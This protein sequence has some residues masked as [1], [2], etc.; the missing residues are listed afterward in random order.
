MKDR[1]DDPSHNERTHLWIQE[2]KEDEEEEA[3]RLQ[4]PA[5]VPSFGPPL[6]QPGASGVVQGVGDQNR[7]FNCRR[8]SRL[9]CR[10]S[11]SQER[12]EQCRGVGDQN[13]LLNCRRRSRLRSGPRFRHPGRAGT[14]VVSKQSRT[15]ASRPPSSGP[16]SLHPT[17]PVDLPLKVVAPVGQVAQKRKATSPLDPRP[18]TRPTNALG[19]S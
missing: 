17:A 18:T 16:S 2:E 10:P 11:L 19:V 7:W 13:R 12:Q 8:R 9:S 15:S 4:L 1:P 14:G 3:L 5:A 6:S